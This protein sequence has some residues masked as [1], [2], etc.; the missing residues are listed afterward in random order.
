MQFEI[1]F[2]V[3]DKTDNVQYS[4]KKILAADTGERDKH[5]LK[6]IK[7]LM[8]KNYYLKN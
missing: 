8:T 1:Y 2:P 7:K 5:K 6:N 3:R 4:N